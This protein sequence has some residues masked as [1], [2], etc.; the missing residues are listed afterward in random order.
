MEDTKYYPFDLRHN[1]L[2]RLP[3]LTKKYP[4]YLS[5]KKASI[6]DI[7]DEAQ[8]SQTMILEASEMRS[9]V[10]LNDGKATFTFVPFP[11]IAQLSPTYAI[12]V[13]DLNNDG[14]KD[15]ILGGN[16]FEV[17]PEFG[18]YDASYG[19]ILI[20]KGKGTFEDKT[21]DYGL[22]VFGQVRSIHAV[23]KHL[24]FFRNNQSIISYKLK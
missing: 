11:S 1:L 3:Y 2:K 6:T 21:Y 4:D 12:E 8:L 23:N 9:G 24:H 22:K 19:N 15:I 7:F 5:F 13:Y 14:L 16:L 17:K 20:N 18:K 10:L